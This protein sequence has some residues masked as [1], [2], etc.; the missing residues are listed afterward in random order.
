VTRTAQL[1]LVLLAA[2]TASACGHASAPKC[3]GELI[4]LL[5]REILHGTNE[6]VLLS[7]LARFS[8]SRV[9]VFDEYTSV[10]DLKEFAALDYAESWWQR[11][12]SPEGRALLVFFNEGAPFCY[13]E[14]RNEKSMIGPWGISPG[15]FLK[16][17]YRRDEIALRIDRQ[18]GRPV[19]RMESVPQ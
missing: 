2:F 15:R 4:R 14:V 13:A 17:G 11:D 19:A 16:S 3:D 10:E 7:D 1:I 12:H 5:E 6:R 18:L 9:L 8:W